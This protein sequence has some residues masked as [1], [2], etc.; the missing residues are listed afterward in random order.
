MPNVNAKKIASRQCKKVV[1]AAV[2]ATAG[3]DEQVTLETVSE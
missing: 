1:T 3:E 2:T